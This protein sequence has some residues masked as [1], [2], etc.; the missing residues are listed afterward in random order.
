VAEY[1]YRGVQT[2]MPGEH[3]KERTERSARARGWLVAT[4]P[5][6]TED[7][8]FRLFGLRW[9]NVS[10]EVIRTAVQELL[11][12][13]RDD[14]G[15]SQLP[16]LASDAYATGQVLVALHQAGG[17]PASDAACSR[18]FLYLVGMQREDGSWFVQPRTVAFN[19]YFDAG[20]PHEKAQFI[21]CAGSSWATMALA[22]AAPGEA[23]PGAT[24]AARARGPQ[25]D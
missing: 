8:A 15:W 2:Y 18:G 7:R 6:T 9:A 25:P 16:N 1:V 12:E 23:V 20:F 24:K 14:G 17:L 13:Q 5:R 11:A 22:L 4:P 3:A 10:P 21:S 19:P